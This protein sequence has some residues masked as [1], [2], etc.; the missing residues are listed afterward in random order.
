ML[1]FF[2][3]ILQAFDSVIHIDATLLQWAQDLG[4]YIYLILFLI[5]FCETGLVVAPFLPGD[6]LLFAIG[7]IASASQLIKLEWIIPLLIIAAILGDSTNYIIGKKWG[8][9]LFSKDTFFLKKK[10]LTDT[11]NFFKK[12]G[13]WA[14]ALA[15][16]I[17]ITRTIAPF[18]AG[19]SQMRYLSFLSF[20]VMGTLVWINLFVLVGYFFGQLE[21]IQK[22]FTYLVFGIILVSLLPI[23][24]STLKVKFSKKN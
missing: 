5:I 1:D 11:E 3:I 17:P 14:V 21:V 18:F 16:F 12:N 24:I 7:A 4:P 15:R 10:Y 19:L 8:R 23:V 6:S 2:N 13:T 22:N 9:F 20:S